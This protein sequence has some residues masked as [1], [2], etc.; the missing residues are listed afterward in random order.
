METNNLGTKVGTPCK[1]EGSGD[2]KYLLIPLAAVFIAILI[3]L[4]VFVY[5]S[6][7][8]LVIG[9]GTFAGVFAFIYLMLYLSYKNT[10]IEI[11]EN[12]ISGR[13]RRYGITGFKA[14]KA[15]VPEKF[16]YKWSEINK[17]R[18]STEQMENQIGLEIGKE[19][20]RY[21]FSYRIVSH[22]E[23]LDAIRAFGGE[24]LLDQKNI[25]EVEESYTPKR[26]VMRI[27]GLIVIVI[28]F[29]LLKFYLRGEL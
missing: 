14:F 21:S 27:I 15:L 8:M 1:L 22:K 13:A 23:A 20:I 29:T 17:I 11:N 2:L 19:M 9:G 4:L 7:E 16:S 25:A 24:N 28:L 5:Y 3:V 18:F 10:Y 26:M 12:G 6:V